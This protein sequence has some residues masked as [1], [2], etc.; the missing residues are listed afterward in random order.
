[1]QKQ[2]KQKKLAALLNEDGSRKL[3]YG[4]IAKISKH[5]HFSEAF[6]RAV[7]HPDKPDWSL[8]VYRSALRLLREQAAAEIELQQQ[9]A[10]AVSEWAAAFENA[11][12]K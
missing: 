2:Q 4:S 5:T 6:V 3:Q 11:M 12:G 8:T 1:M 9:A 7:L 10:A